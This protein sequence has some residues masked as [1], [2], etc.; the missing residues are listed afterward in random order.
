MTGDLR[1][2]PIR[3]TGQPS[4]MSRDEMVDG[5]GGLRPQ[6]RGLLGVLAGLGHGVLAERARRL[7]RVMEEEGAASLLPGSPPDPWRFDPIPLPLSQSEF[8]VLEAGLAQRARLLDAVLADLYGQQRLLAD[9]AC[10]RRWSMPIRPSCGHAVMSRPMRAASCCNSMPP[11]SCARRMDRGWCWRIAPVSPMA[12]RTRCRTAGGSAGWCRNCSPRSC[13]CRIDPFVELCLDML[14][15]FA[16]TGT[17]ALLTPGH[18]DPAWYGHV[19]LAR[20]L[21]CALVEGGDLTVRD[22]GLFLK[23]LRGLQPIGVLLRGIAGQPGRSAGTR[24]GWDRRGRPARRRARSRADPQQ[25]RQRPRRGAGAGSLPAR[26]RDAAARPGRFRCPACRRSGWGMPRHARPSCAIPTSGACVR[27][28]TALRRRSRWRRWRMRAERCS[29]GCEPNRGASRQA[30]WSTPSVAP[31]LGAE[32]LVPRPVLVRMFLVRDRGGWR[33]M[34]GGLGCVL[35]DERAGLASRRAGG[36]QGCL[37]PGGEFGCDRRTARRPNP[38]VGDPPHGR[39]H[40]EPRRRQLFLA[41]ALPGAAG[42]CREAAAHHHRPPQPAGADAARDGRTGG[43]DRLPHAGGAAERRSDRGPRASRSRSGAA[44][45]RRKLGLDPCPARPGLARHRPAARSGDRRDARGHRAR[46]A[47]SGGSA[48]P[49]RHQRRRTGAGCDVRGDVARAGILGH[50]VR[51]GRG[52]HGARRR[53]AVPGSRAPGGARPGGGRPARLRPGVPRRG[54]AAGTRGAR[55]APGAGTVRFVDHLSQPLSGGAAAG[56]GARP[57]AGR[58]WQSARPGVPACGDARAAERDRRRRRTPRS[59]PPRPRCRTSRRRW[60]ARWPR[61][62]TSRW[63]RCSCRRGCA[64]CAMRWPIC[65]IA[66]RG[67][68]S[69][70]CR[71]ARTVGIEA[72]ARSM[73]G[74]A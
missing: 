49:H 31:C 23:T 17:A 51:A 45:R 42:R 5:E 67:A 62:P 37:G 38:A 33:A 16:P 56:A 74:A 66:C 32:G 9:G 58:R 59:P 43:A 46:P 14:R 61:P 65:R 26:P 34:P 40:A 6:W 73:R 3:L 8:D 69:R 64:R 39:R 63:R 47:R 30:R 21:S 2:A 48:R 57:A 60:S 36:C 25:P 29:T 20:E 10:R 13:I 35:P 18:A 54:A 1:L 71:R 27:H 72:P 19:L 53:A 28:S 11:T 44:A 24:S 50:A 12:S 70:C 15:Q 4:S 68:I 22:G 52:E 41:R 7:D 55:A